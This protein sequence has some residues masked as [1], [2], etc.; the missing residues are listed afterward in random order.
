MDIG[1]IVKRMTKVAKYTEREA[2]KLIEEYNS[3]SLTLP[4]TDEGVRRICEVLT[5]NRYITDASCHGGK[6]H[7]SPIPYVWFVCPDANHVRHLAYLI[8][9]EHVANH[10][11]WEISLECGDPAQIPFVNYI[12]QPHGPLQL[13]GPKRKE[14]PIDPVEDRNALLADLDLIGIT[15]MNYFK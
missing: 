5:R 2:H 8:H 9:H 12:L 11:E 15:V 10:F 13:Y 14:K 6:G 3:I 1:T 7:S 4:V